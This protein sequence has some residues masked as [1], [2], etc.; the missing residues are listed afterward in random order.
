MFDDYGIKGI[1]DPTD[2]YKVLKDMEVKMDRFDWK[3]PLPHRFLQRNI[4][5]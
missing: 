1:S 3:V 5:R 4:D 2:G